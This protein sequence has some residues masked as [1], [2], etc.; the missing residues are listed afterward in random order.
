MKSIDDYMKEFTETYVKPA[1]MPMTENSI[2]APKDSTGKGFVS[3]FVTH[4]R[5]NYPIKGAKV[6]I[7]ASDGTPIKVLYTD[8]SG[9]TEKLAIAV[10]KKSLSEAP[11]N[12][13]SEVAGFIDIRIDADGFVSA[14]LKNVPVFDGVVSSQPYDMLF[15]D[16]ADSLEPQVT[17][18]S[19]D[20][21]L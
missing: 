1:E 4:S 21:T 12:A 10:P 16:A 15:S 7:S 13:M 18:F 2:T 8:E 19:N 3:V 9:E 14:I 11:G 20:N 5:G 17:V 6:T